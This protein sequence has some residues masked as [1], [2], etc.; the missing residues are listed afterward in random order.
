MRGRAAAGRIPGAPCPACVGGC[1]AAAEA[2][3]LLAVAA[4][5]VAAKRDEAGLPNNLAGIQVRWRERWTT[6]CAIGREGL[7]GRWG[8]RARP[9]GPNPV[10]GARQSQAFF[11]CASRAASRAP[12][13]SPAPA[14]PRRAC[15]DGVWLALCGQW[16]PNQ[17]R[18][19]GAAERSPTAGERERAGAR[20]VR[21]QEAP[22]SP[23]LT[24]SDSP[25]RP[26]SHTRQLKTPWA[27]R[28][29][30]AAAVT[31]GEL[32]LLAHLDWRTS[33]PT[34]CDFAGALVRL[35]LP[36]PDAAPARAAAGQVSDAAIEAAS[37]GRAGAA[38]A[39]ARPSAIG[40]AA[41]LIGLHGAG[42][43]EAAA[44]FLGMMDEVRGW[45]G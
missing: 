5:S 13:S 28:P 39:A 7:G 12:L 9:E 38:T 1:P 33:S 20:G 32:A 3:A 31:A 27:C 11:T 30:A 19:P 44:V 36:G 21:V 17:G 25:T 6:A 41:A 34:P 40:A 14:P 16:G 15:S 8:R 18:N 42:R 22:S 4:L 24:L 35:A 29:F 37:T 10:G 43:G 45:S 26:F 23:A 2:D